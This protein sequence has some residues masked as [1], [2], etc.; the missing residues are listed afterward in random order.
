MIMLDFTVTK[1][2]EKHHP[3]KF[4][5]FSIVMKT[6]FLP[7]T[8][9]LALICMNT[10]FI[11][12]IC[13]T[14]CTGPLKVAHAQ[15]AQVVIS[16]IFADPTPTVG[17]PG[18][19]FIELH[20]RHDQ[21]IN[22]R[23][24]QISDPGQTAII[25]IDFLLKPDSNVIIT[26]N[27]GATQYAMF[28]PVIGVTGFPSLDNDGDRI[29][30]YNADGAVVHSVS[31]N[32]TWYRNAIKE[33]GGWTLEMIDIDNPC[34]QA[35]NW[36]SSTD[37]SGGTPGRINSVQGT[38]PDTDPPQLI[39]TY[40]TD[41]QTIIA[42]FD[43]TLDST[44]AT[45]TLSYSL[46]Y[47]AHPGRADP[48][49]PAFNEVKL[50]FS[51]LQ[52]EKVYELRVEKVRDCSGNQIASK[53]TV[54]AGLASAAMPGDIVINEILF[55]PP[56]GGSDYV[57]LLNRS[58][59]IIDL[60]QLYVANAAPAMANPKRIAHIPFHLFPGDFICLT[61]DSL[62]VMRNYPG[63]ISNRILSITS[64]PS[65][66]DDNGSIAL[67]DEHSLAIDQVAYDKD[68][69][70]PLLSSDDGVALERIDPH[71]PSQHQA[72]WTSAS[73]ASGYGTPGY[74]NSQFMIAVETNA[75]IS[76]SSPTFSPDN[77]GWED[78][79]AVTVRFSEPNMLVRIRLT[80]IRGKHVRF[81]ANS[82]LAGSSSTFYWDGLDD[83]RKPLPVGVYL[84]VVQVFN[85]SGKSKNLYR[86]CTL[87]KK[88]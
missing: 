57:E 46:D 15:M 68:W 61:G 88:F 48:I 26:T 44:L 81:L 30:V 78:R 59:R 77:D 2:E 34:G 25:R 38:N 75:E 72:N 70:F 82:Q 8:L 62:Q 4:F 18:A 54:K 41:K 49:G 84:V 37:P 69:H 1:I 53:N 83:Q 43:E 13:F 47:S 65:M 32:K 22:L 42:V 23:G 6:L 45:S 14:F 79:L 12:A 9:F 19:E 28:G 16:E 5:S 67:F 60:R 76:L 64:L 11:L 40:N 74:R 52:E 50:A 56:P 51:N 17:L 80:D 3:N 7:S 73:S 63:A 21:V 66:P 35:G 31:Y 86:T 29:T 36:T 10:I 39:R 58:A 55:N 85:A 27:S 24:W 33:D 71:G 20:S 87:A